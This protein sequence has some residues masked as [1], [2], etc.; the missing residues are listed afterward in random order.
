MHIKITQIWAKFV[1]NL[2]C[3][4]VNQIEPSLG[5]GITQFC[6]NVKLKSKIGLGNTVAYYSKLSS[7]KSKQ[8]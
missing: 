7:A 3:Q 2:N 4:V 5:L 1:K 8:A 6:K